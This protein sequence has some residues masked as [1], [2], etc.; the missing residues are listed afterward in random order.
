M[1]P[2]TKGCKECNLT[3]FKGRIG[4]FEALCVSDKAEEFILK[5]PSVS[6]LKEFAIQ[7]GMTTMY[8]DGLVKIVEGITTMEEL[9]RVTQI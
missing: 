2:K 9:E 4:V 5:S 8:Q 1:I 6:A 3:G 7:Q